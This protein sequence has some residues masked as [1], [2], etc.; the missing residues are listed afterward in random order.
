[1]KFF[2]KTDMI[3]ILCILALSIIAWLIYSSL[4]SNKAAKAEI[5]YHSKLVETI[6]LTKG[7]ER[8]F[9]IPQNENV[10]FR[11]NK[12]GNIRFEKSDC[13][14]KVC[15]NTGKQHMVGQSAACLPNAIVLKIV[16][17]KE[18]SEDDLDVITG[19]ATLPQE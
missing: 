11:L 19:Y 8:A 17:L 9:S 14:D 4:F 7:E 16:P 13:P 3:V 15:V 2:K 12:E 5:Y 10:V 1:M 6:D 18:R